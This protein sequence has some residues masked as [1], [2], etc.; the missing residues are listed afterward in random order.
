MPKGGRM[1]KILLFC[2]TVFFICLISDLSY[3]AGSDEDKG[4]GRYTLYIL[5]IDQKQVPIILDTRTGKLWWYTEEQSTPGF[6]GGTKPKF[7]GVTVD[8]LAYSEKDWTE[9][10]KQL[11]TLH[12]NGFVNKE[13]KGFKEAMTGMFSYSVDLDKIQAINDKLKI[14]QPKKE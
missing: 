9:F 11:E 10:E 6:P 4:D 8:G 1:R 14:L 13:L 2:I 3:S 7:Q 12:A 5:Q